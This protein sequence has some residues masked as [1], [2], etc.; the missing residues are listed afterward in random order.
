MKVG[1]I[2]IQNLVQTLKA[3]RRVQNRV[4]PEQALYIDHSTIGTVQ[5]TNK[6]AY[7]YTLNETPVKDGVS[8][9]KYVFF[10]QS[11]K[12][13][14]LLVEKH[15]H[16]YKFVYYQADEHSIHRPNESLKM[17]DGF[18][19]RYQTRGYPTETI[20]VLMFIVHA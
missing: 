11:I 9:L 17:L 3:L 13:D 18:T 7:I 4:L 19:K 1:I 2:S 10:S 12:K 15:N 6:W 16:C 5:S 8:A 20:Q 14:A